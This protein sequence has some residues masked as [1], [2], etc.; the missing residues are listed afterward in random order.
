MNAIFSF[1][2]KT[3]HRLESAVVYARWGEISKR[4]LFTLVAKHR[5]ASGGYSVPVESIEEASAYVK[6]D[7]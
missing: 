5:G 3:D 1:I 7:A 2:L 6:R 4:M